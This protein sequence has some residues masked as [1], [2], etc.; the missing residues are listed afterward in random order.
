LRGGGIQFNWLFQAYF[1]VSLDNA[2]LFT[3]SVQG[4]EDVR[5]Y[6]HSLGIKIK[7]YDDLWTFLRKRE[8]GE[9]KLVISAQIPYAISLILTPLRYT[10]TPIMIDNIKAIKNQVELDGIKQA[11]L[12]DGATFVRW[13][14]WLEDKLLQ[15]NDITEYDAA[16]RLTEFRQRNKHYLGLPY[17]NTSASGP[18]AGMYLSAAYWYG[19][20][21]FIA[22]PHYSPTKNV[23]R[24]IDRKTPYIMCVYHCIVWT[25]G[26]I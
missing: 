13:F 26:L 12:R 5:D 1:F 10:I 9:G 24:I 22:L 16:S 11:Y 3:D 2:I 14:A 25:K 8:W 20:D 21:H 18:N 23:A 6:L 17:E 19:F 7:K 4:K 15:G